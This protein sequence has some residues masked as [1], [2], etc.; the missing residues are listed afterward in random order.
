MNTLSSHLILEYT[1]PL[2][3][4]GQLSICFRRGIVFS[5]YPSSSDECVFSSKACR[6]RID[7]K[8]CYFYMII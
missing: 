1:W 6:P 2:C 5:L 4:P 8:I 3:T 7:L